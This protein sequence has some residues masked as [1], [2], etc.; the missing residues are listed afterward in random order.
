MAEISIRQVPDAGLLNQRIYRGYLANRDTQEIER[1]H[2]FAGRY[3]N[4]YLDVA[5]L[6]VL[7]ELQ[8]IAHGFAA[9]IIDR[10]VDSISS[11]F[12]FNEMHPGHETGLH[13]HDDDDELLS[14][15]Y[16]VRVPEHSG[17]L[18]LGEGTLART[19]KVHEGQF[20]LFSPDLPHAVRHNQSGEMRLS[21]A[22]NFGSNRNDD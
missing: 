11:S 14:G 8:S 22:F 7:A 3:E 4:I 21:I 6:P 18:V 13:T 17:D 9:E 12:W 20:I 1:T 19:L 5:G 16:Y 2:W 15:V 10:P